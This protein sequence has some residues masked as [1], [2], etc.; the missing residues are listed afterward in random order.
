MLTPIEDRLGFA[1]PVAGNLCW[2]ASWPLLLA[3]LVGVLL[4]VLSRQLPDS[5]AMPAGSLGDWD[6]PRLVAYLNGKGLGLRLVS[7]RADGL[8]AGDA[9]LTTTGGDW[10]ELNELPKVPELI[11]RWSGTL[12]CL[13]KTETID[14][15]DRVA[16]W[17]DCCLDAEPFL[18]FGD[19]ELLARV[20]AALRMQLSS[21][22]SLGASAP[23]GFQSMGKSEEP[24]RFGGKA[25]KPAR[26]LTKERSRIVLD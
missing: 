16:F 5:S 10:L 15:S 20:R 18:L 14:W 17:G 25:L 24:G 3:L 23:F 4:V 7:T 9:F 26:V 11:H 12:Y 13:R 2:R 1:I 21:R 19:R 22:S 8:V 6:I